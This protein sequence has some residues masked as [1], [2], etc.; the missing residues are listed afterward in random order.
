MSHID[1]QRLMELAL[2]AVTATPGEEQHLAE[3]G[4]CASAL[5]T[6]HGMSEWLAT[7][8]QPMAPDDFV[9]R[10]TYAY[11]AELGRRTYRTPVLALS[12]IAAMLLPALI[13]VASAW[14]DT[15][16]RLSSWAVA[17]RALGDV[18]F[19][20]VRAAHAPG[21]TLV[22][23]QAVLLCVGIGVLGRLMWLT[24]PRMQEASR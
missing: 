1:E 5:A 8:P 4:E 9:V 6:E 20:L 11:V 21:L 24:S 22:A 23:A 16:A 18:F 14:A 7:V 19:S 15:L 3:C 2:G 17:V 10:A 13:L 12:G